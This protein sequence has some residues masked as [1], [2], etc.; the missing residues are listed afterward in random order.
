MRAAQTLTVDRH[1]ALFEPCDIFIDTDDDAWVL[2]VANAPNAKRRIV[3]S[4]D[5]ANM[6][7]GEVCKLCRVS[8]SWVERK[9]RDEL[10]PFP[11]PLQFGGKTSA[12][13]WRRADV[14]AWEVERAKINGS[15]S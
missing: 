10:L 12:R 9:S 1:A 6:T 5:D 7:I 2:I 13:R 4:D 15:A 8:H 11:Q 14:V 3:V